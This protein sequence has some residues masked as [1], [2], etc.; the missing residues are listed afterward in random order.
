MAGGFRCLESRLEKNPPVTACGGASP[1]WQGGLLG[2]ALIVVRL[3][4]HKL[5]IAVHFLVVDMLSND[6]PQLADILQVGGGKFLNA[7]L[8]LLRVQILVKIGDV[9]EKFVQNVLQGVLGN[10]SGAAALL[11]L[12]FLHEGEGGYIQNLATTFH[13]VNP[14]FYKGV[15]S[16]FIFWGMVAFNLFH[17]SLLKSSPRPFEGR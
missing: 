9:T 2:A 4:N 13:S 6:G 7:D 14:I 3:F 5:D 1:L 10:F 8:G 12:R 17:S 16:N 15:H 11:Q